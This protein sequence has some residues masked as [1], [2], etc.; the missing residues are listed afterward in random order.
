MAC[1]SLW[2]LTGVIIWSLSRFSQ[3]MYIFSGNSASVTGCTQ[4]TDLAGN[5]VAAKDRLNA[6]GYICFATVSSLTAPGGLALTDFGA[7]AN[8]PCSYWCDIK[9]PILVK[10]AFVF[11]TA[12]PSSPS[13]LLEPTT[14]SVPAGCTA[15]DFHCGDVPSKV[16]PINNLSLALYGAN[17]MRQA[18]EGVPCNSTVTCFAGKALHALYNNMI[19][20][21]DVVLGLQ[22]TPYQCVLMYLGLAPISTGSTCWTQLGAQCYSGSGPRYCVN[23]D[24][25]NAGITNYVAPV[26]GNNAA[27]EMWCY[28]TSFG[29]YRNAFGTN[30]SVP[31]PALAKCTGVIY[32]KA[33]IVQN[34]APRITI[35]QRYPN[36]AWIV[37]EFQANDY[38]QMPAVVRVQ[39]NAILSIGDWEGG[40]LG[41]VGASQTIASRNAFAASAVDLMI[42]YNFIGLDLSWLAP[43]IRGGAPTDTINYGLLAAAVRA[44]LKAKGSYIL[45]ASVLVGYPTVQVYDM[46]NN[47]VHFDR[48]FLMTFDLYGGWDPSEV[49][50]HTA[51][52][53]G[54][55]C[56]LKGK[57]CGL[58]GD[59]LYLRWSL[60]YYTTVVPVSKLI[61]GL[62]FYG[63]GFQ[64]SNGKFSELTNYPEPQFGS[65][66]MYGY[67]ELVNTFMVN[68]T[69]VYDNQQLC[70]MAT[71]PVDVNVK[72]IVF[73][74]TLTTMKEKIT[75]A[76]T[77]FAIPA[78][79]SW[80]LDYDVQPSVAAHVELIRYVKTYPSPQSAKSTSTVPTYQ[81]G[82][83][84]L[85]RCSGILAIGAQ[86]VVSSVPYVEFTSLATF[87]GIYVAD[88]LT[89]TSCTPGTPRNSAVQTNAI[90]TNALDLNTFTATSD[91]GAYSVGIV[92][93]AIVQRSP[94]V[95]LACQESVQ[96][97]VI[98][99]LPYV[100]VDGTTYFT[101]P[102]FEDG[103]LML[104]L[105]LSYFMS[106]YAYFVDYINFNTTCINYDITA[107]PSCIVTACAG[108]PACISTYAGICS[109]AA[110]IMDDA[111]RSNMLLLNAF[112]DLD[113]A[114]QKARIYSAAGTTQE[115]KLLGLV[116]IGVSMAALSVSGVALGVAIEASVRVT[117]LSAQVSKQQ[118]Q[119]DNQQKQLDVTEAYVSAL[120]KSVVTISAKLDHNT[121]LVNQR[122]SDLQNQ[123]NDRFAAITQ[124]FD[125][126][127]QN[128][129][130][131]VVDVNRKFA[132]TVGYQ[133]WYQQMM[134]ITNQLTQAAMQ[135]SYKAITT[136]AC[137]QSI[138]DGNL[139]GCPTE[140]AVI[141]DH[142]GLSYLK[143]VAS[144]LYV[145]SNLIIVSYLPTKLTPFVNNIG[146]PGPILIDGSLCWPDYEVF[147]FNG[148]FFHPPK[149]T[150]K[151]CESALVPHSAYLSCAR[152]VST[153]QTSCGRCFKHMCYDSKKNAITFQRMGDVSYAVAAT[154][155]I[156]NSLSSSRINVS[157]LL[158]SA[159]VSDLTFATLAPLKYVNTSVTL[160]SVSEDIK[161]LNASI[162]VYEAQIAELH[163]L[164]A[165]L[166]GTALAPSTVLIVVIVIL[167]IIAFVVVFVLVFK[168]VSC[169]L[170]MR[171]APAGYSRLPAKYE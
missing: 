165:V 16:T 100:D 142:P 139:A 62:A 73:W 61:M 152:N 12:G 77:E 108:D 144:I 133:S 83:G 159:G 162:S 107:L 10:G 125:L 43:T 70:V 102:I 115:A 140:N 38:I 135:L 64:S 94:A 150:A 89:V 22:G 54:T 120:A 167:A 66:G 148:S 163:S 143:S 78:F 47:H 36:G 9:T 93:H 34:A 67:A 80:A 27:R 141:L 45:T 28:Y 5:V 101:T 116:A 169:C 17:D 53:I 134:S 118:M 35:D 110:G 8:V 90:L 33:T 4:Y 129:A 168:A 98:G 126:V 51:W 79:F 155:P 95:T 74:D 7:Q 52:D 171:S 109:G 153:C 1:P 114:H 25:K 14:D 40:V 46:I 127:M 117:A 6:R 21:R 112:S 128:I 123:L 145:N 44:A 99:R 92:G 49:A 164:Y 96:T 97:P 88:V 65:V 81:I 119:I 68:T 13:L 57:Q 84:P 75:A 158:G 160:I 24:V 11:Y 132:V 19:V 72:A 3:A 147:R 82:V 29:Q 136:N 31:N 156:F 103:L 130:A 122:V 56:G 138:A 104:P 111:K 37:T 149:C 151:Y 58:P 170:S 87:S 166:S 50:C 154:A 23:T 91:S 86:L 15:V 39:P 131:V 113:V 85:V 30:P 105:D 59:Y 55:G 76:I 20:A 106:S 60:T 121:Q 48:I 146:Y 63:R 124:N 71:I 42:K 69:S 137:L 161:A 2:L 41:W 32:T 157:A 26:L 18:L